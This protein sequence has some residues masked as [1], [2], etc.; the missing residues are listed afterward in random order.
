MTSINY[1]KKI[2]FLKRYQVSK[3][4]L[5]CM[6]KNCKPSSY[7]RNK[8]QN[9]NRGNLIYLSLTFELLY[10]TL[11]FNGQNI[12]AGMF[13]VGMI[14]SQLYRLFFFNIFWFRNNIR[15]SVDNDELH[16]QKCQSIQHGWCESWRRG[17]QSILEGS[18]MHENLQI[19]FRRENLPLVS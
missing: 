6:K 14:K 3:I 18:F 8:K 7:S 4:L 12:S 10:D 15:A 17:L 13:T 5:I 16:D 2:Q 11:T 1:I 9:S 19:Q